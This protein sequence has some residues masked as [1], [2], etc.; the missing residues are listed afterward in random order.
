[1]SLRL[2]L[3]RLAAMRPYC[4]DLRGR[5]LAAIEAGFLSQSEVA[6]TFSVSLSTVEKRWRCHR[7]TGRR[8]ALPHAGGA[9][10]TLADA[11]DFLR[12][13]V[14]RQPDV[15]LEELCARVAETKG[16]KASPSMMCRELRRLGLP[17]KKS[18]SMTASGIRRG[19][20]AFV[21]PSPG[22]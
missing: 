5:V 1:M 20:N 12:E 2:R 4:R 7:E 8:A 16:V 9:R 3:V 18:P 21:T 15:T 10:R 22:W 6:E 11:E 14:G 13:E 17:R 19:C